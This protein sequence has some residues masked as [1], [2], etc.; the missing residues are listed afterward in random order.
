MEPNPGYKGGGAL[1]L[2][3]STKNSVVILAVSELGLS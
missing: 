1:T 3:S 2:S